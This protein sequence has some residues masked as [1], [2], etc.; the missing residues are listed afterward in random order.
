MIGAECPQGGHWGPLPSISCPELDTDYGLA[1]ALR[2]VL[3][4]F[5]LQATDLS[6]LARWPQARWG[7]ECNLST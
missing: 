6:S 2:G 7:L 5:T 4:L 1:P 3:A